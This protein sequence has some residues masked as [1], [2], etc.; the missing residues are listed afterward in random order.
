VEFSCP[1]FKSLLLHEL[2][3]PGQDKAQTRRADCPTGNSALA[4]ASPRVAGRSVCDFS[5]PLQCGPRLSSS[6]ILADQVGSWSQ[7]LQKDRLTS[8]G[9]CNPT[10]CNF[11]EERKCV[12][13]STCSD[14]D[15]VRGLTI[16][17]KYSTGNV[18]HIT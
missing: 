4:E 14:Y 5:L 1:T 17:S 9:N 18:L 8:V 15:A 13:S 11:P 10:P 3:Q 6:G 7:T 16:A 12:C 2:T